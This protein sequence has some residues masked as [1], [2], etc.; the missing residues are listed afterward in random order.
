MKNKKPFWQ[1]VVVGT[2]HCGS[3]CT[4]GDFAS[5]F[6]LLLFPLRYLEINFMETGLLISLSHLLSVCF[7]KYY[8][9]KPVKNLFPR[10]TIIAA[11]KPDA[12]SLT[13]SQIGMY[14]WMA[15]IVFLVFHRRLEIS[16]PVYWF[17]MQ[18]AILIGFITAYL[19]NWWLLRK[20]IKEAS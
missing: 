12:L 1:G 8:A 20:G 18:I 3:V 2:L 6:F 10:K 15:I 14:A 9:I 5:E 16:N 13:F 7:S 11:L 17:M 4:L 19:V